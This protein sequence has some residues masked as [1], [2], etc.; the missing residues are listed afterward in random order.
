MVGESVGFAVVG[1][2]VGEV[3]GESV[4]S[5][6]VGDVVGESVGSEVV[7][8]TVGS[9]VVG[10][11]VG[12]TVGS[13][14]VGE[15]VGSEVVG[16]V[17]GDIV[18][19]SVDVAVVLADEDTVVVC[20]VISHPKSPEAARVMTLFNTS[21]V[22]LQTAMSSVAT[23]MYW[24][25]MHANSW[26]NPSAVPAPYSDCSRTSAVNRASVAAQLDVAKIGVSV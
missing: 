5:E 19:G 3:V 13:E 9:D 1:D 23:V 17:E 12:D 15:V 11:R 25:R 8:E 20:D 10:D 22:A 6:V 16:E 7:G 24:S 14:V 2:S 18:G 4:G 21:T 26:V